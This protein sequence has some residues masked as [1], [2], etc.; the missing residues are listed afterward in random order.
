MSITANELEAILLQQQ[1]QFETLLRSLAKP[2]DPKPQS[3]PKF[4]QYLKSKEKFDQYMER[5]DQHFILHNAKQ[6]ESK[7]ACFL[8]SVGPTFYAF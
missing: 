4:E 3:L 7:K 6:E 2:T 8:A 5:L 1:K